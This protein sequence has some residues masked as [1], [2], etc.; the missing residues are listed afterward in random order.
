MCLGMKIVVT[1]CSW[2]LRLSVSTHHHLDVLGEVFRTPAQEIWEGSL[3]HKHMDIKQTESENEWM[4]KT[5]QSSVDTYPCI[6]HFI[7]KATV[8]L[9][10]VCLWKTQTFNLFTTHRTELLM[11]IQT[12]FDLITYIF[13]EPRGVIMSVSSRIK[14]V[15]NNRTNVVEAIKITQVITTTEHYVDNLWLQHLLYLM[16]DLQVNRFVEPQREESLIFEDNTCFSNNRPLG[17][18]T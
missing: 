10:W 12:D 7:P 17:T 14:E 2:K 8:K 9:L 5:E 1:V 18:H 13:I 4:D 15:N 3:K 6:E 16:A 11:E